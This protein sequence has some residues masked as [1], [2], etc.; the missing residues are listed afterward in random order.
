MHVIFSAQLQNNIQVFLMIFANI[1][2][3]GLSKYFQI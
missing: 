1:A 3:N 2:D